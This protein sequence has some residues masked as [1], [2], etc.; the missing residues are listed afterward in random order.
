MLLTAPVRE[1]QR[2]SA[3]ELA[4]HAQGLDRQRYPHSLI[5]AVTH[6]DYSARLQTVGA[7]GGLFRKL[8][9]AFHRRT[10]CPL[11][12]NT[13]FNW[14]WDPIVCTPRRSLRSV[15]VL[16]A[17]DVL[18]LGHLLLVKDGVKG[19]GD[20]ASGAAGSATRSVSR[21]SASP[22]PALSATAD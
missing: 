10:G 4:R 20:G 2:L 13:S 19:P 16:R 1:S 14:G 22:R 12:V 21:R 11:V 3:G 15:S 6:V 18:C 9:V 8:L 5:P 7:E 17:L